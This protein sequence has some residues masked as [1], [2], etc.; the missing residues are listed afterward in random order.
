MRLILGGRE[1]GCGGRDDWGDDRQLALAAPGP[2]AVCLPK[3][4]S[5]GFSAPVG[6][7][8]VGTITEFLKPVPLFS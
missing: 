2:V 6:P 8:A 3:L 7:G 5:T 4:T 1:G